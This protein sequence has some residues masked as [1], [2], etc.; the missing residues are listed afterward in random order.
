M[1]T[2]RICS[3]QLEGFQPSQILG[4][5]WGKLARKLSKK[6][7]S[8]KVPITVNHMF[9]YMKKPSKKLADNKSKHKCIITWEI[10]LKHKCII[11][12]ESHLQRQLQHQ[13]P[14]GWGALSWG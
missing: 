8:R 4:A 1:K 13:G 14:P 6:T 10:E 7:H 2:C 11:T 12:W 9:D 5:A 3:G